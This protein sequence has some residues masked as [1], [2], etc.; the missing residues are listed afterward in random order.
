MAFGGVETGIY[1]YLL[2][3][4]QR[5][6]ALSIRAF[7]ETQKRTA[8]ERQHGICAACH[9]PFPYEQMEGDHITPWHSG[10]HT[11]LANLQMLCR[12]CNRHKSGN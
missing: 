11:D 9:K 10:G 5:E 6:R 3:G 12:P 4:G 7:T 8:Y 1:E 2:S